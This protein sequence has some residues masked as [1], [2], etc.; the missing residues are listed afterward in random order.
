MSIILIL[1]DYLPQYVDL[2][3]KLEIGIANKY[4]V[5]LAK[6]KSI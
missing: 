1:V 4:E 5:V 2:T 6:F 3:F